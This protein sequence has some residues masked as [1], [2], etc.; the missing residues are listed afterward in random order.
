MYADSQIWSYLNEVPISQ[1][2]DEQ[3]AL[4]SNPVLDYCFTSASL[5]RVMGDAGGGFTERI[6][7][8]NDFQV[9]FQ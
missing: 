4:P 8:I 7:D 5:S 3:M 2:L 9:L 6:S 1:F